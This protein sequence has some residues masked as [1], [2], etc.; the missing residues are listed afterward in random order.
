MVFN[1]TFNNISVIL[2]RSVLLVE[3]N[4]VPEENHW[5]VSSHWQ[6]LSHNVVIKY[7]LPWVGFK[8]TTLVKE[9]WIQDR[10]VGL[11]R[12]WSPIREVSKDRCHCYEIRKNKNSV[13]KNPSYS[14][15]LYP[16]LPLSDPEKWNWIN[17]TFN[18]VYI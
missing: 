7:T 12:G 13:P 9:L 4:G 16:S 8:L 2:W 18:L 1:A 17:F 6:T 14:L 5:A 11:T 10:R 15:F 3:E